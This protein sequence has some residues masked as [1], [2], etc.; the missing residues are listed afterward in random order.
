MQIKGSEIAE[1]I[2][3]FWLGLVKLAT[4]GP[5]YKLIICGKLWP[6]VVFKLGHEHFGIEEVL[7]PNGWGYEL[8]QVMLEQSDRCWVILVLLD[9][10]HNEL[11]LVLET[12]P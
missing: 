1:N 12:S 4:V 2:F 10:V 7:Y 11:Y 9:V 5:D 3:K 8:D 6:L